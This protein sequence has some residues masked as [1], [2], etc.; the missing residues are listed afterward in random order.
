MTTSFGFTAYFT[1]SLSLFPTYPKN[2]KNQRFLRSPVVW[3][4]YDQWEHSI[5]DIPDGRR[6]LRRD[7]KNRKH[8]YVEGAVPDGARRRRFLR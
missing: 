5:P 3:D 7:R 8:L 6:F 2:R 4:S 1:A